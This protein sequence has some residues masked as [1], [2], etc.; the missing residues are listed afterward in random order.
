[1]EIWIA[2]AEYREDV[3]VH[4]MKIETYSELGK[5]LTKIKKDTNFVR[6]IQII[7]LGELPV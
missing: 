1:M 7:Y 5:E 3:K 2:I 4:R 6:V